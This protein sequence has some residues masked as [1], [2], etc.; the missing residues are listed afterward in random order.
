MAEFLG[1][2]KKGVQQSV[3]R[4]AQSALGMVS[5]KIGGRLR[6]LLEVITELFYSL[7]TEDMEG[8][9]KQVDYTKASGL[10][11]QQLALSYGI[12]PRGASK[13]QGTLKATAK[14]V[15]TLR[16]GTWLVL[17]SDS[18]LRFNVRED[19]SYSVT[20]TIKIPLEGEFSGNKYN[21]ISGSKFRFSSVNL[22]LSLQSTE[23]GFPDTPGKDAESDTML[24]RRI[25]ARFNASFALDLQKSRYEDA[26]YT[27]FP[28]VEQAQIVRAPRGAGSLSV[29]IKTQGGQPSSKLL[30]EITAKLNENRLLVRDLQVLA[31]QVVNLDIT[32]TV[33]HSSD[34]EP[35][36]EVFKSLVDELLI[37]Q[38][39]S[40]QELYNSVS[41]F[42]GVEI[43][44][45]S[46][47][48]SATDSQLIDLK[49]LSVQVKS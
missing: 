49:N 32:A 35:V 24:R 14:R 34:M 46:S 4:K 21:V 39:L 45:P 31:P 23:A 5:F 48:L 36:K 19:V 9:L 7:K 41:D 28:T 10:H 30:T 22:D 6:T 25:A 16:A 11:L 3:F 15:G 1:K 8:L 12:V 2:D 37:G 26:V 40:V 29:Y 43:S 13:A 47:T 20:G 38:D 27:N 17:E 18:A 33:A 44:A 42:S